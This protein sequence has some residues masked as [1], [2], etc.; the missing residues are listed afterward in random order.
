PGWTLPPLVEGATYSHFP[1]RVADRARE[2]ARFRRAGVQAGEVIEYSVPYTSGY[3]ATSDPDRFPNSRL[4]SE[5]LINLP[6]HPTLTDAE[7][8]RVIDAAS[9]AAA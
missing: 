5:H 8:Q 6:V 9:A 2:V 3:R 1:V 4:C 7:R